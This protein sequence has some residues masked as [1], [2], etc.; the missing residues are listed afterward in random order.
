[1]PAT[2]SAGSLL[3]SLAVLPPAERE[4]LLTSLSPAEAEA[5]LYDWRVWARPEQLLPAGDWDTWLILS[6]RGWGKTRTGA[7]V[8][9]EWSKTMPRIALVGRTAADVR[10]VIVEGE[11]GLMACCPRH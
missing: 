5:I 11:S 10:D 7:E 3:S 2:P 1:M 8:V 6:G 4:A 9:R